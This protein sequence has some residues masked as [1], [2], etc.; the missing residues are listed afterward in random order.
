MLTK[1]V[2]LYYPRWTS[3]S[4]EY[5]R[6]RYDLVSAIIY[7]HVDIKKDGSLSYPDGYSPD[8]LISYAHSKGAKV[9][10]QIFDYSSSDTNAMLS[11]START[12]AV[13]NVFN[14]V[15]LHNY[16][17][18]DNDLESSSATNRD[19]MTAFQQLLSQ[20]L[21][22]N[23]PNYRL[24]IAIDAYYPN[25]DQKFDLNKLQNY[26]NFI[27][28]MGYDWGGDWLSTGDSAEPNSP[29]LLAGNCTDDSGNYCSIKHF[30]NEMNK[31]KFLFGVPWYGWEYATQDNTRLSKINGGIT[32]IAYKD[33][34]G[35]DGISL[36]SG[37]IRNFDSVWKTPWYSKQEGSQWYQGHYDDLQSLG[38]KYDLTNSEGLG[39]IGIF[40]MHSGSGK[41][42]LWQLIQEKF[43]T[44]EPIPLALSLSINPKT[45]TVGQPV[46]F[47]VSATGGKAPYSYTWTNLPAPCAGTNQSTITCNPNIAGSYNV[48]INIKDS[49]GATVTG[50]GILTVNPTPI[51]IPLAVSL[52]INPKIIIVGQHVTFA[53]SVTGGKSPYSYTWTNLPIPCI[54]SN[55]NI[56]QCD[57]NKVGSYNVTIN[58]KDSAGVTVTTSGTLTVNVA[59]IS[60]NLLINP[61]FENNISGQPD[62]WQKKQS[63]TKATFIY[64]VA[65]RDGKGL[66]VGI[67]YTSLDI[68]KQAYWRQDINGIDS[69]KTYTISGYMKTDGIKVHG[70]QSGGATIQ[71]DWYTNNGNYIRSSYIKHNLKG[72]NP[73]AQF[74]QKFST[75]IGIPTH[76]ANAAIFLRLSNCIGKVWFDDIFFGL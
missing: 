12:N 54:G 11:S 48:T 70:E 4:D 60:K 17:G 28:M 57:P 69:T 15:K 53:S 9:I 75:G 58:I 13:N 76:A 21:W 14:E 67:S 5:K 3:P 20:V 31:S 55:Q 59:P 10:L 1:E 38:Q 44:V 72:T 6:I 56:I 41:P 40:S 74:S 30:E 65:G 61:G 39:G 43:T 23:N 18:V 47:S 52:S 42:E 35:S 71:V 16:D 32:E 2:Q 33:F 34:V 7:G 26:V 8:T 63:G 49:A 51:P 37:Y 24:S 25:A 46:T 22:K 68:K 36:P 50:S 29:H 62:H 64:P 66:C 73:W 27:M 19:N 45:I